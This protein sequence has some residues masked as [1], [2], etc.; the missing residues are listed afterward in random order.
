MNKYKQQIA[1]ITNKEHLKGSVHDVIK[2][3]D[4]F[5]GL[6]VANVLDEKDIRNMA[7]DAIVMAMANPIPEIMPDIAKKAGARI[8]CTGR[9]DFNNQVNNVLAFPGIFRGTLDVRARKI[10]DEM[11][12]AAAE[13]IAKVAQESLSEDYVIPKAFDKRTSFEVALAVARKA[14]EQSIARVYLSE[15]ELQRRISHMLNM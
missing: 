13:A 2:G 6:S 14:I 10:T 11:K 9:S 7:K 4:V 1:K 12:I 3:A 8:V 15:E 5:I